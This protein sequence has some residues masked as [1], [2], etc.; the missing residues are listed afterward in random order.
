MCLNVKKLIAKK[1]GN[2]GLSTCGFSGR[3]MSFISNIL[4]WAKYLLPVFVIV[5]GILDFMKAIGADKEDEMKKA[6]QRF[7]KRLIAA[8]LLFIV[9]L[10]LEFVLDKMGFGYDDCGLF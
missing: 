1:E 6:Q 5:L 7:I 9:P 2:E 4:R 3:L 10:I 8:A